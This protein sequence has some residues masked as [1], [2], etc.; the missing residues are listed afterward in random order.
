MASGSAQAHCSVS[1]STSFRSAL[2]AVAR[3]A[4]GDQSVASTCPPASAAAMLG[5][6]RPQPSSSV[7]L[8]RSERIETSCASATALAHSSAQ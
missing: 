8:P 4:S 3:T 6:P 5:S 7:G 2:A 1:S